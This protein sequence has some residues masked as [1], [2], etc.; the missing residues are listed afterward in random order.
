MGIARQV[1]MR[2]W[3][4]QSFLCA[5][6]PI[7]VFGTVQVQNGHREKLFLHEDSHNLAHVAQRIC[8]VCALGAF[9]EPASSSPDH[10]VILQKGRNRPLLIR[11]REEL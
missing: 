11:I 2:P 5:Y 4:V 9:S 8:A 10:P 1:W 7:F 3:A 6:I